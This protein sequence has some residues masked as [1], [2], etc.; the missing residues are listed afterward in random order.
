MLFLLQFLPG[1]LEDLLFLPSF[2]PM[3]FNP[4][5]SCV[6]SWRVTCILKVYPFKN[7]V[8]PTPWPSL[9][10]TTSYIIRYQTQSYRKLKARA[11]EKKTLRIRA[12]QW[13]LLS[14]VFITGSGE[15]WYC[16]FDAKA[17]AVAR[18]SLG[19]VIAKLTLKNYQAI[20]FLIRQWW[21][22]RMAMGWN[23]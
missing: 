11:L 20:L 15:K 22:C 12:I 1:L 5:V 23:S 16:H 7:P 3:P 8:S 9:H 6:Q 17:V 4:F 21:V 18:R 13:H 10:E 2:S 14:Q 19:E